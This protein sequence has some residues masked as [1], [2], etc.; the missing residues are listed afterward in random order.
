[1]ACGCGD[2]R[3]SSSWVVLVNSSGGRGRVYWPS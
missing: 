1:M 2:F 3:L